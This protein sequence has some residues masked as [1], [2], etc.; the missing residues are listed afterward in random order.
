LPDRATITSTSS[1]CKV[2]REIST[3]SREKI[4][5]HSRPELTGVTT[6]A[7]SAVGGT[8][9]EASVAFTADLLLAVVFGSKRLQ[10]R[11]DDATTKTEDE[12]EG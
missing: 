4:K 12:V 11:F 3:V 1:S 10:R 8:R 6:G 9:G 2:K 5:M 7:F